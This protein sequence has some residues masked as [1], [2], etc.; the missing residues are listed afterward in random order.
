[1]SFYGYVELTEFHFVLAKAVRELLRPQTNFG[2]G[3]FCLSRKIPDYDCKSSC[4]L[5]AL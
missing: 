1:M 3:T 4:K 2:L 5:E